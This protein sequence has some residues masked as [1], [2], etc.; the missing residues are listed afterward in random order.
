MTNNNLNNTIILNYLVENKI[1]LKQYEQY[2][3]DDKKILFKELL[4]HTVNNQITPKLISDLLN[5]FPDDVARLIFI[6][7]IYN[8]N[9][10]LDN[11]INE[12][13]IHFPE[14]TILVNYIIKKQYNPIDVYNLNKYELE[15]LQSDNVSLKKPVFTTEVYR[16][17]LPKKHDTFI[18]ISDYYYIDALQEKE[19]IEH[20]IYRGIPILMLDKLEKY[21]RNII[22]TIDNTFNFVSFYI[23]N[24]QNDLESN[25]Q[26]RAVAIKK[27][28]KSISSLSNTQTPIQQQIAFNR[29]NNEIYIQ[30]LN[31]CDD[32]FMKLRDEIMLNSM[33]ELFNKLKKNISDPMAQI[34]CIAAMLNKNDL[35]FNSNKELKGK[36]NLY[37]AIKTLVSTTRENLEVN[38]KLHSTLE[39]NLIKKFDAVINNIDYKI[40][41]INI[42]QQEN[43]KTTLNDALIEN[44]SMN[45]KRIQ[46]VN[47]NI[48]QINIQ[49]ADEKINTC[50]SRS[51]S[52]SGDLGSD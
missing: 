17:W 18:Q 24:K 6:Q 39:K 23:A 29:N 38:S 10:D 19:K 44:Q 40:T 13:L 7:E 48:E 4:S 50:R 20:Y 30:Y 8:N 22:R 41:S 27:I 15:L 21:Q 52:T 5:E 51:I 49:N 14:T 16:T 25:P 45:L 28:Q 37:K 32:S 46:I 2:I 35:F 33:W 36:L 1:E 47:Q 11:C 9:Q 42:K 34:N 26:I 3:A 43:T 12:S 31:N